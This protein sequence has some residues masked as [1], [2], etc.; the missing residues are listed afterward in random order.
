MKRRRLRPWVRITL[1]AISGAIS[2]IGVA[3]G[4]AIVIEAM[5][6]INLIDVLRGILG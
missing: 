1:A 5:T 4:Y 3:W 2:A 6:G